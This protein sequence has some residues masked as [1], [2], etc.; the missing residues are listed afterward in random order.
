MK[1]ED[2]ILIHAPS[3]YDFRKESILYGPVSDLVP[4]TPVFEMYPI[5]FTTLAEYLERDGF[6]VRIVNLAVLM[7]RDRDFDAEKYLAKLKPKAFG[8]DLHW[9][10]HAHGALAVGALL[11]KLHPEIPLMFG[12]FSS[13]FFHEELAARPETDFVLRGDSTEEP[14]LLL[15][16][17]I[18]G[19]GA[20]VPALPDIPNL[21]WKDETGTVRINPLS[22]VPATLDHVRL[23]YSQV[24]RSVVRS[25]DLIGALPFVDWLRYPIMAALSCRGCSCRC[26]T[27]GGSAMA[28][29]S[30][31]LRGGPAYR[32]PED[33]AEDIWSMSRW[34]KGPVFVL[35]DIRFGDPDYADRFLSRVKGATKQLILE[36][37]TPAPRTFFRKLGEAAPDFILQMSPESHD[38]KVRSAFG[39]S[40]TNAELEETIA[41][42]LEAGCKRFDLFFMIG[43]PEQTYE[44][45][46]ETVEYCGQL[47]ERFNTGDRPR[48]FPFISPFAPFLDPG[49][50]V[51]NNPEKYG[52]KLLR[53][54]LE[55]HRQALVQP[56]WKHVLN[57]ETRWMNRDEIATATYEAGL[58]F[59]QLKAKYGLI[60]QQQAAATEERIRRAMRLMVR[61]DE[62][63]AEPDESLRNELLQAVK[64]QVDSANISTVCDKRE[65]E[66]QISGFWKINFLRGAQVAIREMWR[67]FRGT[68]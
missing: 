22:F 61:I 36:V 51:F 12:G 1:Q 44:S 52:Y 62:I 5:G 11:K 37:L 18:A 53:R 39:R 43:L 32:R 40:Y 49:S 14:M 24:V 19:K 64:C 33:L 3:V 38:E 4:S 35:G 42:A 57:Y 54:T 28:M 6:R 34:S 46:M 9:L 16:R 63:L 17:H 23:D 58:R 25:R 29:Q 50:E 27:C 47:M 8:I 30:M 41:G 2:L 67:E 65:L 48:L 10:P 26:R 31:C 55:E 13:T 59:N 15:M 20:P 56:S 7:M 68:R 21:T 66:A 60:G 45:V